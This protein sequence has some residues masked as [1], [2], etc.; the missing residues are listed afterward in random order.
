MAKKIREKNKKVKQKD[1]LQSNYKTNS[2]RI[3]AMKKFYKKKDN[4]I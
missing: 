1:N 4:K 2:V 3:S